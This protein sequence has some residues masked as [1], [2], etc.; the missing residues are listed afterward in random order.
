ME[1]LASEGSDEAADPDPAA[2]AAPAALA[3]AAADPRSCR[4]LYVPVRIGSAGGTQLR[5]ARTPGGARTAVAFTSRRRLA[6]VFGDQQPWVMLA[7]PALRSL[8]EP[9][10]APLVT[11]DPRTTVAPRA[12]KAAVGTAA[13]ATASRAENRLACARRTSVLP[14]PVPS[15]GPV[16]G[17]AKLSAV[18]RAVG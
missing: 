8:A 9:L 15:G 4:P 13:T 12:A 7:E 2:I 3:P 10:G 17:P 14:G 5:F 6:A 18:V 16:P 11:I 1:L